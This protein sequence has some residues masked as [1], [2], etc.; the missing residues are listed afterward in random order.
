MT[1]NSSHLTSSWLLHQCRVQTM[2]GLAAASV[3]V[4]AYNWRLQTLDLKLPNAML[5]SHKNLFPK[6]YVST[7]RIE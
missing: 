1:E 6:L 7:G 3:E 5:G 4:R 2:V